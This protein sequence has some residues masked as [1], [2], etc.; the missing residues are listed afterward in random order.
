MQ[1]LVVRKNCQDLDN[2]WMYDIKNPSSLQDHCRCYLYL[3]LTLR[4]H[5]ISLN[6]AHVHQFPCVWKHRKRVTNGCCNVFALYLTLYVVLVSWFVAFRL[7]D[8]NPVKFDSNIATILYFLLS[9]TGH[10]IF[11]QSIVIIGASW[12]TFLC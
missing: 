11:C 10:L 9:K 3:A 1:S 5:L 6:C 8:C 4:D 7:K 12:R 2:T